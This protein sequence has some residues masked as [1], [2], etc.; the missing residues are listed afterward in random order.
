MTD[1]QLEQDAED[2]L[3][4]GD[5]EEEVMYDVGYHQSRL[6]LVAIDAILHRVSPETLRWL[7]GGPRSCR[8]IPLFPGSRPYL[9]R[10][11]LRSIEARASSRKS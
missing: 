5:A 8:S 6:K 1:G 11:T 9:T 7:Q 2:M 10:G 3:Q 4:W